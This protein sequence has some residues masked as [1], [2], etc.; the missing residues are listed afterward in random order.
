MA[1]H[2]HPREQLPHKPVG[3][4]AGEGLPEPKPD[5]RGHRRQQQQVDQQAAHAGQP[6]AEEVD[7]LARGIFQHAGD[8]DQKAHHGNRHRQL[9]GWPG[10]FALQA[11]GSADLAI[12]H[13]CHI[14]DRFGLVASL[15]TDRHHPHDQRRK[16]ASGGH[17]GGQ[18][19]ASAE[20]VSDLLHRWLPP[21]R[22]PLRLA[23]PRPPEIDACRQ[24]DREPAEHFG[25]TGRGNLSRGGHGGGS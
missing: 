9:K 12:E 14:A 15:L 24:G 13:A 7:R 22:C 17:R 18:R 16:S 21:S 20:G 4:P 2:R 1:E 19:L 5:A 23:R 25:K 3:P 10:E 11:A 8:E 6:Q